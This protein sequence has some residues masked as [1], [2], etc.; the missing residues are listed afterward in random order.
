MG[1]DDI[2]LHMSISNTSK[3]TEKRPW[4]VYIELDGHQ[5]DGSMVFCTMLAE[6]KTP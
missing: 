3:Y 6:C 2:G 5:R 4:A 1:G